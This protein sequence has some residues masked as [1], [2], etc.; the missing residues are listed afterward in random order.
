M[1]ALGRPDSGAVFASAA[2][3]KGW[4][5]AQ[6][7]LLALIT[8]LDAWSGPLKVCDNFTPLFPFLI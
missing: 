5:A 2:A 4:N 8:S 6:R 1:K 7:A 3:P